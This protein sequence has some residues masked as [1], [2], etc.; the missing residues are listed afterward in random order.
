MLTFQ[1][2]LRFLMAALGG[3]LL[4]ACGKPQEAAAP[5]EAAAGL[6]PVRFQLDW[7]PEPQ[8]GGL[9]AA[10]ALGY[11]AAEGLQVE[12]LPGGPNANV[13]ERIATGRVELGQIEGNDALTAAQAGLPMVMVGAL[14]QHDP[15]VFL[16]HASNPVNRFEDLQGK[17]LKARPGW[18]F[19]TYLEK[20]KGVRYRLIPQDFG[21]EVL[22]AQPATIQQG[23]YIAEPFYLEKLG[24]KLKWLHVWDAGYDGLSAV[25][26][27]RD[28]LEKNPA[29]VQAFLRAYARGQAAYFEGDPAPADALIRAGNPEATPEFLAWSR[30]R[31]IEQKL[32]IGDPARGGEGTYVRL[33]PERIQRQIKQMEAIGQ[34]PPRQP[35]GGAGLRSGAVEVGKYRPAPA[36]TCQGW[37]LPQLGPRTHEGSSSTHEPI[38]L[39]QQR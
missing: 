2:L 25:V 33:S 18:A 10:L 14:F 6:T 37:K 24:V 35:P 8:H 9:Y 3:L 11:F 20:V 30:D 5:A 15:S 7:V 38:Q 19:L 27:R 21:L 12:L 32:A 17:T 4:A 13:R 31:I 1:T 26:V 39:R 36:G 23:Y 22:A 34:I 28:F 16:M 29:V